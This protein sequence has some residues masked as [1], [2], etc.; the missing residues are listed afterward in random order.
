MPVLSFSP[1]QLDVVDERLS[2]DGVELK[3]R[4]KPF[5]IL[6]FLA[7]NPK[8]LVT[9]DELIEAVW[10]KVVMSES[11]L[12]THVR[13]LRSV[14]GDSIIETV[15]GRG[16]RFVAD[17]HEIASHPGPDVAAA[18]SLVGR[19]DELAALRAHLDAAL[20]RKRQLVFVT[21][22][23]GIGKTALVD[24]LL[25]HAIAASAL[26]AR[27]VCVEQYGTGEAFLPVLSALGALCRGKHGDHV[28]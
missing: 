17:V 6:K 8:R 23:T 4:R 22:R 12:R 9:Q 7:L 21:G 25:E 1:F 26:V 19:N 14:V 13:D 16:Y 11:L 2:K 15:I 10:G 20:D 18:P 24:A 3:L 28:V 5:A 27:G